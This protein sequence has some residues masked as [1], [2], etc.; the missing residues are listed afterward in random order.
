[1]PPDL[2]GPAAEQLTGVEKQ[3]ST[4]QKTGPVS[5]FDFFAKHGD[6][7]QIGST[8]V[9]AANPVAA[10]KSQAYKSAYEK[11]SSELSASTAAVNAARSQFNLD[12]GNVPAPQ[13]RQEYKDLTLKA[14]FQALKAYATSVLSGLLPK[15]ADSV[16][17]QSK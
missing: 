15:P 6:P 5:Q 11:A 9:P 2:K 13:L 3:E 8:D 17:A 7:I 16:P 10:E 14:Q 12:R 1:M 4:Q